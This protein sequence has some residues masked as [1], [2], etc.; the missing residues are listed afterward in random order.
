MDPETHTLSWDRWLELPLYTFEQWTSEQEQE[1]KGG[2]VNG[3]VTKEGASKPRRPCCG[4]VA[5]YYSDYVTRMGL[6]KN[7]VSHMEISQV[8]NLEKEDMLSSQATSPCS[9]SSPSSSSSLPPD[10]PP[11]PPLPSCQRD[12]EGGTT[13]ITTP[14][15]Q[16]QQQRW[17]W[18]EFYMDMCSQ[19]S[20]ETPA[21]TPPSSLPLS[22]Q[23]EDCGICCRQQR[24]KYKWYT[25]GGA[26]NGKMTKQ[27]CMFSNRLVL[28]CGVG[29]SP[30][31]LGVP[32]EDDAGFI[33]HQYLTFARKMR[34]CKVTPGMTVLVV[35]AGLCAADAV[36][37][38]L[39]RGAKVIHVF[40]NDLRRD[41]LI[42]SQM[43]ESDY[44][45][46]CHVYRLMQGKEVD[47]NYHCHAKSRICKFSKNGCSVLEES[48]E[49]VTWSDISLGAVLIGAD[50]E[51]S[52]LPPQLVSK[53]GMYSETLPI[54][55]KHN[56][57]YTD[58][59]TSV[60]VEASSS[61]YAVGSLAGDSFV[62]FGLGSA[63]AAAHHIVS[64]YRKEEAP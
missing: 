37:L 49:V 59:L 9:P 46:Y 58:P 48:Q 60:T 29:G 53:L 28:A 56:P 33:T 12:G 13:T 64:S 5:R 19:I 27:L 22:E 54:N 44:P 7:F 41:K 47:P 1:G 2:V 30:R 18:E 24:S 43:Y 50:A 35:G 61:L 39:D 6:D 25:R 51:M 20:E 63:L 11:P 16:E 45:G 52:F 26:C 10:S 17:E 34:G 55:A 57:M 42:F 15:S 36:L 31:T 3:H 4:E 8:S 21:T 32:G 14:H 23:L 62:R 40:R 38:A